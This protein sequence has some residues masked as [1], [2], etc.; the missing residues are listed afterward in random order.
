MPLGVVNDS[1]FESELRNSNRHNSIDSTKPPQSDCNSTI[2]G[3]VITIE[4]GRGKDSVEVPDSLRKIIGET[5]ELEGRK[6]ALA[7]ASHFDISP[8]SVSAYANGSTSTASMDKQPNLEHINRAK[9]RISKKARRVA[10]KAL[11]NITEDK[12]SIASAPELAH[13]AR[14]MGAIVKDMEPEKAKN[15]EKNGPTFVF[16]AP[17]IVNEAKFETVYVKE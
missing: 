9:E 2:V 6:N 5:S 13:V 16:Y 11:E 14:S 4:K 7:L 17:Q 10:I 12:L 1:E 15:E 3:E 8:S